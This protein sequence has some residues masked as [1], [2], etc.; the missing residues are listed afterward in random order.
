MAAEST[1]TI[2]QFTTTS[3][4]HFY[5]LKIPID[6]KTMKIVS[7]SLAAALIM[8]AEAFAPPMRTTKFFSNTI[9]QASDKPLTELCE[10]TKEACDAVAPM[11]NGE[12]L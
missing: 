5:F 6:L 7:L 10:I 4:I 2:H 11:L 1:R 12:L 8:S 3:S 9:M